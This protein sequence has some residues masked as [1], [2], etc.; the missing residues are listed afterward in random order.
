MNSFRFTACISFLLVPALFAWSQTSPVAV[1][2]A[3]GFSGSAAQPAPTAKEHTSKNAGVLD[4]CTDADEN[5][6]SC[7][8]PNEPHNCTCCVKGDSCCYNSDPHTPWCAK[9]EKGC[10]ASIRSGINIKDKLNIFAGG[11]LA[12]TG[13]PETSPLPFH[14]P[15][16]PSLALTTLEPTAH[17]AAIAPDSCTEWMWQRDG[18]YWRQCVKDDGSRYCQEADDAKGTNVRKVSC[19]ETDSRKKSVPKESR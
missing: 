3:Q 19:T 2:T 17:I 9:K 7:C 5:T 15:S 11:S 8:Y 10:K 12:V 14:L 6:Y 1:P 4:D 13:M 16:T 18:L